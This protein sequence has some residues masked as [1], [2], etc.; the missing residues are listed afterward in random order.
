MT[1]IPQIDVPLGTRYQSTGLSGRDRFA[2]TVKRILVPTD[3]RSES[4][5]AVE[6]GLALAKRFGA[7]L[8]LLHIYKEP[9]AVDYIRGP[10]PAMKF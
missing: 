8:T 10:M 3:L 4:E 1:K 9:Y 2:N 6:F 5:S 7:R